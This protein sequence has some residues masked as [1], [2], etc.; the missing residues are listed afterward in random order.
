[1]GTRRVCACCDVSA[2]RAGVS[3]RL[4]RRARPQRRCREIGRAAAAGRERT[5]CD[6]PAAGFV[7]GLLDD[8][9]AAVWLQGYDAA[10]LGCDWPALERRLAADVALLSPGLKVRL[11]GRRA[12]LTHL[13][14]RMR[15]AQ[16]HE[17]SATDLR[18]RSAGAIGIISYGWQLDCTV[19]HQRR[20]ISGRD[21]LVLRATPGGWQLLRRLPLAA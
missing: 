17:Y 16:V 11:A 18:G 15:G 21:L 4:A 12:V 7:P 5:R 3:Q 20:R 10:W 6:Q 1:M 14:A 13:R 9:S 8:L 2:A 19:G